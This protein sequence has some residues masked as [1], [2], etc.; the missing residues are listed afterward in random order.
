MTNKK[1]IITVDGFSS[2]GKSTLAKDLAKALNYIFVDSGAMYRAITLYFLQ[3]KVP[4]ENEAEVLKALS[5]IRL[6]FLYNLQNGTS[7]I[8]LNDLNVEKEIREMFINNHVSSVAAIEHVR[9]FAV[10]AQQQMGLEKGIVMDGRDIGTT[11]FPTAELKI[12]VTADTEVRVMRRYKELLAKNTQI[13]IDEIR[14][15]LANR[16]LID[17]TRSV[18]PLRKADDAIIL[19]NTILTREDQLKFVLN[20]VEEKVR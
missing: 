3:H 11:V 20:L 4:I 2:C 9:T 6:K 5:C 18:S 19:D 12:F 13:T 8:L 10:A 1:I 15:N 16:D 7:D 17:S 14:E